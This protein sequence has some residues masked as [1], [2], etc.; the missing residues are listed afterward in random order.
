MTFQTSIHK[1]LDFAKSKDIYPDL[2]VIEG[3]ST[4]P[5][6]IIE[7][8]KMLMFSSNNYLGLATDARIKTAVKNAVSKYGMGSGGSRL[9]SGNTDIQIELENK[10]ARFKGEESAITFLAGY[11]A[12]TG[13]IPALLNPPEVSAAG[14]IKKFLRVARKP[15]VFSDEFN[16]ASIIDGIRQSKTNKVVFKHRDMNDLEKK[17]K[18]EGGNARKLIITDGV[19]SMDGDIAPLKDMLS[20]A[21]KYNAMIFLDDAH[22]SGVLGENGKG[23]MEHFG[24]KHDP[25]VIIMGTF[26]KAFGGVGGF[27]AGS[28]EISRYLRVMARTHVFSAPIPPAIASGLI[29]S[30]NI[31]ETEPEHRRKLWQNVKFIQKK[32]RELKYDTLGSQTQIIPIL[33]GDENKC[34]EASRALFREGIFAPAVHWP[35]VAKGRARLRITLMATHSDEQLNTFIYKLNKIRKIIGW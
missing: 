14:V 20:L 34:V 4:N 25:F 30:I 5:E 18:K 32:L 10:I 15:V 26:T 7:G 21:H 2:H 8:K 29:E 16:H 1:V 23:T 19:F 11:M 17:L 12:N 22:A 35:A 24:F 13:G 3:P 9:I 27:I 6:V 31:C 33:I 28:E